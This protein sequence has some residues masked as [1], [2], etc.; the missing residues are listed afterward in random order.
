MTNTF[1]LKHTPQAGEIVLLQN[2]LTIGM[3]AVAK[4]DDDILTAEQI[5][6]YG[7]EI[8]KA[9]INELQTWAK[10]KSFSSRPRKSAR[11]II[12]AMGD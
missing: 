9:M 1:D 3:Q 8:Q 5:K 11:N 10:L 6:Q 2:G 7:P 4:R 12:C